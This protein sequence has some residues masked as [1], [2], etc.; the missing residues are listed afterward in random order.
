MFQLK[1]S[2]NTL[3]NRTESDL[4]LKSCLWLSSPA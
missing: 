2:K 3:S 4:Q 1:Q